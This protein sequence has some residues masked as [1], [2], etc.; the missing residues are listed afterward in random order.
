M[1]LAAATVLRLADEPESSI[2]DADA[3]RIS[4]KAETLNRNRMRSVK[5]LP[6]TEVLSC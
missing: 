2:E 3:I 5:R 4:P 1:V 6:I